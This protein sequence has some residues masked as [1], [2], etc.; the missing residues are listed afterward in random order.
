MEGNEITFSALEEGM[1]V[2]I[3]FGGLS[4]DMKFGAET[5]STDWTDGKEMKTMTW[6][7]GPNSIRV[8]N[9]VAETGIV[10]HQDLTFLPNGVQVSRTH[11]HWSCQQDF[12]IFIFNDTMLNRHLNLVC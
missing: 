6:R 2:T 12:A 7:T 9:S 10:E 8:R 11:T 1:G 3:M 5:V 4:L